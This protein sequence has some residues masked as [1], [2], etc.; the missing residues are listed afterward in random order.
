MGLISEVYFDKKDQITDG[1]G[2][3]QHYENGRHYKEDNKEITLNELPD[4]DVLNNGTNK[5]DD[6]N[7]YVVEHI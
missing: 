4:V 1:T 5:N 2:V 7:K 3:D 6:Q